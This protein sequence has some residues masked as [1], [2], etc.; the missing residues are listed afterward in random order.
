VREK[1][2]TVVFT[3]LSIDKV[4]FIIT[5]YENTFM[6]LVSQFITN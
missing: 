2:L 5:G 6:A 3:Q 4:A 1:Q